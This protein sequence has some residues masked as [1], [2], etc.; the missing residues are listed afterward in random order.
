MPAD[1]QANG[2]RPI[3]ISCPGCRQR[4]AAGSR[5][6]TFCGAKIP[7]A[8]EAV[9]D[10][11]IVTVLFIDVS[12]FT[13][14]SEQLDPE[15]VSH[16][17]N[18][19][20]HVLVDPIYRYGGVVDKYIGDAIMALFGAPVAHEDDPERAVRAAWEM[21]VSAQ[22]FSLNLE[23]Q[24]GI[25]LKVRIG[26]NTGLVVAGAVGGSQRADYTVIGDT[27]NLAQRMEAN[28]RPGKILVTS[29]TYHPTK[30]A[31]LFDPLA[32]ITVKGKS[33]PVEVYEVVG[34][35][36]RAFRAVED[37]IR[38]VGR[39]AE[40][41]RLEDAWRRAKAGK[42]QAVLLSGDVGQGKSALSRRFLSAIRPD[43]RIHGARCLSYEQQTAYALVGNLLLGCLE[44][45]EFAPSA[46]IAA[47]LRQFLSGIFP[48]D[49]G[50]ADRL[51]H[52]LGLQP[53]R[54][55]MRSLSPRQL[56][57]SAFLALNDLIVRLASQGPVVLSLEDLHW[58]DDASLEWIRSLLDRLGGAAS[59]CPVMVLIQ[60]RPD[61][62]LHAPELDGPLAFMTIA[63][64]PLDKASSL[65]L[66]AMLLG[67]T[68][69]ALS[70]Q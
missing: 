1:L 24:T 27:V 65:D 56:R 52:L 48:D 10:R 43:A 68:L 18:D 17:I 55:D 62:E 15:A 4:I 47:H 11:R 7:D 54:P 37:D 39:D 70:P 6:C 25:G 14:M 8:S 5:F 23:R 9:A 53:E 29:E 60:A 19:F 67:A 12:G 45:P 42:P 49:A 61:N 64:R 34:P 35:R 38:V 66:G 36:P 2:G 28:A 3:V 30:H 69:G 16:I 46:Q 63:L 57:T 33:E 59:D 51:G 44:L 22:E 21:Q 31:F 41:E 58:A 32:P 13:A 20:F 26:L 50:L 40:L